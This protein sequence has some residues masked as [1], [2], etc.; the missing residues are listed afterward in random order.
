[1]LADFLR[2]FDG[3]VFGADEDVIGVL[4]VAGDGV[5]RGDAF[6]AA[7]VGVEPFLEIILVVYFEV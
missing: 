3:R 4:N 6:T 5:S 2:V 1:M 7:W